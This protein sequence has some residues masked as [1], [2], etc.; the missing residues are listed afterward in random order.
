MLTLLWLTLTLSHISAQTVECGVPDMTYS[1]WQTL[2]S[3]CANPQVAGSF[4][5]Y[6]PIWVTLVRQSDGASKMN[7]YFSPVQ[8]I[9]GVN[10]YFDNG[11]QWRIQVSNATDLVFLSAA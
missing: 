4:T 6:I 8:L 9:D 11:M 1:E 7:D 10:S 2:K 3:G 5:W